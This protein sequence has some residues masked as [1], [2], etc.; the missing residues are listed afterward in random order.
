[1]TLLQEC[2]EVLKNNIYILSEDEQKNMEEVFFDTIPF[3]NWGRVDWSVI[4]NKKN[5]KS[6]EKLSEIKNDE[7]LYIIWSDPDLPIIKSN[8]NAIFSNLD[9]ITAVSFD[10]WLFSIDR[11]LIIEFY[12]DGDIIIGLTDN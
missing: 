9:D 12:H 5:I 7:E 1:M 10:T 2:M 6:I 8:A 11:K 3:T 4:K